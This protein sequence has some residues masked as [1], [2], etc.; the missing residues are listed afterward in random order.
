MY[1]R[2]KNHFN[3]MP[4]RHNRVTGGI[5]THVSDG[6]GGGTPAPRYYC[7]AGRR[8]IPP[9]Q[10]RMP[11]GKEEFNGGHTKVAVVVGI[12]SRITMIIQKR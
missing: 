10:C 1:R 4:L 11:P 8:L 2:V 5:H 9:Q 3:P 6:G 12:Y 7:T